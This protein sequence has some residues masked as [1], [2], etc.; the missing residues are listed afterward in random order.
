MKQQQLRPLLRRSRGA[1][2]D[3]DELITAALQTLAAD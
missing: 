2:T 3:E 1:T